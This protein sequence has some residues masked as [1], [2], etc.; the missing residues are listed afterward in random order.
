MRMAFPCQ[1]RRSCRMRSCPRPANEKV[2]SRA[3]LCDL[4]VQPCPLWFW[5][6]MQIK[7]SG[8]RSRAVPKQQPAGP[9]L[10]CPAA[11]LRCLAAPRRPHLPPRLFPIAPRLASPRPL[12]AQGLCRWHKLWSWH[13]PS[14]AFAQ[15][16]ESQCSTKDKGDATSGE[17]KQE[18]TGLRCRPCHSSHLERATGLRCR[19]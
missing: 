9:A 16:F 12:D 2:S 14:E 11:Q 1:P 10:P 18:V 17:R 3:P 13:C 5:S 7:L 8:P 15:M 4:L 6:H 19:P